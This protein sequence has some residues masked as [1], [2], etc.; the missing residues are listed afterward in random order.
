MGASPLLADAASNHWT[1]C[2]CASWACRKL[3]RSATTTDRSPDQVSLPERSE[4][5]TGEPSRVP[6]CDRMAGSLRGTGAEGPI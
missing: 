3:F 1:G 5:S 6:E 4:N 2:P